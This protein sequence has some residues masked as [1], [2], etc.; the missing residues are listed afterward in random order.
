MTTI[1]TFDAAGY[2]TGQH[3]VADPY[4]P[5]PAGTT[6][7]PPPAPEGQAPLWTGQAWALVAVPASHIPV[8]TAGDFDSALT[9]HLDATAQVKRYDN[10]ITCMVR[11]GF[12]GPFQAEGLAFASWCDECNAAAY[13]LMADVL[14]GNAPM[15]ESTE[16]FIAT[17]PAMVW[18]AASV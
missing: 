2:Y 11:A 5:Q 1:Y 13:A 7:A 16:A 8:L 3:I 17:L 15:P 12:P 10:R 4:A 18:P 6:T 14:A 9:A